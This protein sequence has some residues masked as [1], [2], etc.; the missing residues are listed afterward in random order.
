MILKINGTKHRSASC[1]TTITNISA[2]KRAVLA[3]LLS[4][5][6]LFALLPPVALSAAEVDYQ[7][8]QEDPLETAFRKLKSTGSIEWDEEEM[9]EGPPPA[10]IK[11]MTWPLKSCILGGTF[12]SRRRTHRHT[13]V[14]LLADKGTPIL[15]VLDG[16]VEV[17]SNG[18][19][20]FRGYG[21]VIIVNHSNK[22]WTLYSH[23]STMKVRV[24]QRVK[25]GEVIA[26]V[27]RTGRAS[28]N[29]LHFEVRNSRGTPLNPMKYLPY[30]PF[31]KKRR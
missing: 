13:G 23:C 2:A 1:E 14:D 19:K 25:R 5:L 30:N 8:L 31:V 24:G 6:V 10:F 4:C 22:L 28:A 21:K 26:A 18:G 3:A 12:N 11:D 17:A 27:G 29:H 20:G 7:E 9:L 15:S 16:V